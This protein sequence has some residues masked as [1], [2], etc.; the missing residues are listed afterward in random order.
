MDNL[1]R[2]GEASA[3][4]GLDKTKIDA[5]LNRLDSAKRL[6]LSEQ[7]QSERQSSK[8]MAAVVWLKD[9]GDSNA[10]DQ[11]LVPVRDIG[12]GGLSFLYD[13]ALDCGGACYILLRGADAV[14]RDFN[15]R[16]VHCQII[17]GDIHFIGVQSDHRIKTS[18]L[19]PAPS[20][21]P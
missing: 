12:E 11:W 15:A 13:R 19:M 1:R 9:S 20:Q 17:E 16:I 8:G 10:V 14:W 4:L 7:R 3:T 5:L 2:P 6:V 18:A 21:K